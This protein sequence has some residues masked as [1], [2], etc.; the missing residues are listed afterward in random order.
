MFDHVCTAQSILFASWVF[1]AVW[2]NDTTGTTMLLLPRFTRRKHGSIQVLECIGPHIF[3]RLPRLVYA[4]TRSP[5][6]TWVQLYIYIHMYTRMC[7]YV[8]IYIHI[9]IHR[10]TYWVLLIC[11]ESY[12]SPT[13]LFVHKVVD[14]DPVPYHYFA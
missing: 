4:Q 7:M 1:R 2:L 8:Y 5:T 12:H 14:Q 6:R 11:I 9:Y 3:Q 10:Y 13:F